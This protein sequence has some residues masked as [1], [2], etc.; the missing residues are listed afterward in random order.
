ALCRS[1]VKCR[2]MYLLVSTTRVPP[3]RQDMYENLFKKAE[4]SG[5]EK[6]EYFKK[7]EPA[8]QEHVSGFLTWLV[9]VVG[10]EKSSRSSYKNYIC[11]AILKDAGK[12]TGD[13]TNDELS[14]VRK[15]AEY[16]E[17]LP[18]DEDGDE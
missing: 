1:Y 12:L 15:F 17:T 4:K 14:A 11:K 13:L 10:F 18:E 3:E 9:D 16:L 7:L 8:Q 5:S 6:S 2:K